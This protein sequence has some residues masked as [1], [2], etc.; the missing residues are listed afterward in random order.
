MTADLQGDP[1]EASAG[2]DAADR[3][4]AELERATRRPASQVLRLN[5]G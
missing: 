2:A 5:R 4:R 3:S 1:S